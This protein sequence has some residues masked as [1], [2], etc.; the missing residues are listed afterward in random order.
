MSRLIAFVLSLAFV[1]PVLAQPDPGTI[2]LYYT[3]DFY[4]TQGQTPSLGY[5]STNNPIYDFQI[6][7]WDAPNS[8]W[9]AALPGDAS[10]LTIRTGWN[11]YMTIPTSSLLD[12]TTATITYDLAYDEDWGIG[13][14]WQIIRHDGSFPGTSGG[15]PFWQSPD[16]DGSFGFQNHGINFPSPPGSGL[17]AIFD[18]G[19]DVGSYAFS[20]LAVVGPWLVKIVGLAVAFMIV[21]YAFVILRGVFRPNSSSG[22]SG[23]SRRTPR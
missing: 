9:M 15:G 1:S 17:P 21:F 22:S 7:Q 18:S 6:L 5:E 3:A 12:A 13:E 10:S 19:L 8:R 4:V 16:Q 14:S 20:I 2:Q 23:R 11:T